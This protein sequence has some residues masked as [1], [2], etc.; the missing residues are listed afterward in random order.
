M[1]VAV[2]VVIVIDSGSTNG[3][4]LIIFIVI[5]LAAIVVAIILSCINYSIDNY[6][7]L[8]FIHFSRDISFSRVYLHEISRSNSCLLKIPV[9]LGPRNYHHPCLETTLP[10]P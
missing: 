7:P 4:L 3:S 8:S 9:Y 2:V 10:A 6:A 5:A 1:I